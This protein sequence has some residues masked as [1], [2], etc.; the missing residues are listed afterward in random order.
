MSLRG[1]D[2]S[3]NKFEVKANIMDSIESYARQWETARKI[4]QHRSSKTQMML[5]ICLTTLLTVHSSYKYSD[6]ICGRRNTG[7]S[8]VFL[9]SLRKDGELELTSPYWKPKFHK[10]SYRQPTIA[11]STKCLTQSLSQL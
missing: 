5:N 4:T 6:D 9:C 11:G 10:C 1:L 8:W 7:Y 3:F 2:Y